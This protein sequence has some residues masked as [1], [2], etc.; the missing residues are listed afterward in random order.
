MYSSEYCDVHYEESYN[1]VFVKWKKYCSFEDY[2][3]PLEYALEIIKSH[4]NCN[5]VADTRNGFENRPEDT[6]W[7]A[8]YFFIKAINA[9]CKYIY[10]IID[11]NNSLKNELEGQENSSSDGL[12][13]RYI[14]S[15]DEIIQNN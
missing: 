8:E 15:L 14:F 11:E 12:I 7:V 1:V 2:R 3:K 10:F 9:G 4:K 6:K 13:F 5:Y